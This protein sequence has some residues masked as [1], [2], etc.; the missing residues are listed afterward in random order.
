TFRYGSRLYDC[1]TKPI[2]F[3]RSWSRSLDVSLPRC[4]PSTATVPLV[5]VWSPPAIVKKVLFPEP[6]GPKIK[7]S[8]PRSAWKLILSKTWTRPIPSPKVLLMFVNSIT[9]IVSLLA[10]QRPHW[11]NF[12]NHPDRQ[13]CPQDA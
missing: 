10:I 5:G 2:L 4:F 12:K 13:E 3:S 7:L 8:S 6:E 11:V 9:A 1:R